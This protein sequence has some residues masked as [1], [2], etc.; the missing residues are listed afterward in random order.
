MVQVVDASAIG[1]VLLVE[2]EGSWVTEQTDG[3]DLI[4]PAI[5][6]FEV[7]NLCWKRLRGAAAEAESVLAIWTAWAEGMPVTLVQPHLVETLVLARETGM[8]YYDASYL[9][10]AREHSATLISLD[11]VLVRAAHRLALHAPALHT[12]PRSRS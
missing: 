12:T 5:L 9:Q 8:T 11:G 3:Q 6:A 7:G 4:A 1:A 10:L 2:P